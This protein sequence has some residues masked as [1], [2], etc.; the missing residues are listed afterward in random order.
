METD[1]AGDPDEQLWSLLR[2]GDPAALG[3]LFD[4]HADAVYRFCLYRCGSPADAED[5]AATVFLEAWRDR[6]R[7][8]LTSESALP[9]L[10]GIAR[11]LCAHFHRS[12]SRGDRAMLRIPHHGEEADC[13]EAVV[14]RLDREAVA[15]RMQRALAD[16]PRRLR[17]VVELCLIG[18]MN[19]AVAAAALG[20]PEGTV[21]SRLSRARAQLRAHASV[22]S[23][24]SEERITP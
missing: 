5:L 20:V 14:D 17:E 23:R 2:N 12:R 4:R 22:E 13:A 18:E 8:T 19:I 24:S 6:G 1:P 7:L 21:K 16:L 9:L 11:H 3:A 10:Y 15:L